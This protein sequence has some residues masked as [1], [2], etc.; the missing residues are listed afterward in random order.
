MSPQFGLTD[1]VILTAHL[2]LCTLLDSITASVFTPS[3]TPSPPLKDAPLD[4]MVPLRRPRLHVSP[5]QDD[6]RLPLLHDDYYD[7][8]GH[9][10][11]LRQICQIVVIVP[12]LLLATVLVA[13]FVAM[14]ESVPSASY[15]KY[16]TVTGYFLQDDP[17]TDPS[18]FDYVSTNFGLI[19]QTYDTD[20]QFDPDGQKTQWE[21]FEHK[22]RT[23]NGMSGDSVECKVLFLGRHGQ[24]Y[25]NVAEEFYGTEMWDCYWSLQDGNET[26]TWVDARLTDKG[27]VQAEVAH[28]AWEKQ[29]ESKIPFPESYYVSPLNRCLATA[30]ITF[31][32][33]SIPHTDP[34]RPTIKELLRETIGIHTCDRRS[35]KS[36][37]QEE[38]P[39]YTFEDNFAETDPLWS[40]DW[41]ESN[42]Q[43]D[44][45][46][47]K[48]L[49]DIFTSDQNT[50]ISLTAHSGAITSILEV[51]GHR[52]FSLA[53]GGVIPVLVRA[54]RVAGAPPATKID[55][56]LTAPTCKV[57]LVGASAG[58]AAAR[59]STKA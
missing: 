1:P 44:A 13:G 29:I 22:V 56:P 49:D 28:G 15:L 41:R 58:A 50:F 25:H 33:L 52:P 34:F 30:S 3:V 21:R 36:A 40:A 31:K 10:R 55:P 26:T 7:R 43:R 37:I 48:L 32:G 11:P 12:A 20:A 14:A 4:A 5:Q 47:R 39:L 51:V 59:V 46:L 27:V 9:W 19:N 2:S 42:S 17:A 18:T 38:Y 54:E 24:G 53:T 57:D 35:S 45:R 23:M 8:R 16:S 6:H